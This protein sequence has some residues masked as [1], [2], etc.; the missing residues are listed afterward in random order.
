M[1]CGRGMILLLKVWNFPQNGQK[2]TKYSMLHCTT[3]YQRE[4][5]TYIDV[6]DS[7]RK[8]RKSERLH[9]EC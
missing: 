1:C 3:K 9:K 2:K 4:V 8:A 7:T 5:S 6:A